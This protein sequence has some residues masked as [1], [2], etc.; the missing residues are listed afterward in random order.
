M[1]GVAS[2]PTLGQFSAANAASFGL[3]TAETAAK[4]AT[5]A[6]RKAA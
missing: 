4:A 1:A 2:S 3:G 5:V 6:E